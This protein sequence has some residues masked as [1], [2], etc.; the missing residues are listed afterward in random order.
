[1]TKKIKLELSL[2]EMHAIIDM[3][4]SLEGMLGGSSDDNEDAE[5]VLGFDKETLRT[6]KIFDKMFKRNG[7][8]R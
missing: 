3:I 2:T 8:K 4:D 6:I 1:M 7:Y 5:G